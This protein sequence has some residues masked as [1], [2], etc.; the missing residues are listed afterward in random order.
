MGL[1]QWDREWWTSIKTS[2][3]NEKESRWNIT[4]KDDLYPFCLTVI[5]NEINDCVF[6]P[7]NLLRINGA[8]TCSW[9]FDLTCDRHHS[10]MISNMNDHAKDK[11]FNFFPFSFSFFR[12]Q[13]V[14]FSQLHINKKEKQRERE[15]FLLY[16]LCIV[17]CICHSLIKVLTVDYLK[18][19][20]SR[21]N[22][23]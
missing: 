9:I 23:N 15:V 20:F 8:I 22:K 7:F 19:Q 6:T 13:I 11:F 10:T 1:K 3:V 4:V 5:S 14:V 16:S 21:K 2:S 17:Y 18:S 12:P